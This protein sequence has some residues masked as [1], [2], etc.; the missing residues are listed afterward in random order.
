MSAR[1]RLEIR[2]TESLLGSAPNVRA[3]IPA[4]EHPVAGDGQERLP[5]IADSAFP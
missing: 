1:T 3:A 5:E 2:D 4:L